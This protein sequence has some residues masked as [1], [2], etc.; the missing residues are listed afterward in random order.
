MRFDG[1]DAFAESPVFNNIIKKEAS[2]L[3]IAFVCF[4]GSRNYNL[5]TDKSDYDFFIIYYPVFENFFTHNFTRFSVIEKDYDY[6]I[7]PFHEYFRHAMNGN[8]KFIEPL[9]CGTFK[10]GIKDSERFFETLKLTEKIKNF[11]LI[12]FEKN[13][14]AVLGIIKNKKINVEKD[15]Y[16]SNTL[17]YKD[18]YGYDIKEAINSLRLSYLLENYIKTGEFSFIVK[19]N[20]VY[21]EFENYMNEINAGN[22]SKKHYLDIINK[23][24]KDLEDLRQ[25]SISKEESVKSQLIAAKREIENDIMNI[26]KTEACFEI[27]KNV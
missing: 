13:F 7:T 2:K 1:F 15:N 22:I 12:N 17:K 6:F 8:I 5:E 27:E 19:R 20:Y 14:D 10:S 23:K 3:N 25:V 16:T 11:I 24:I 9:I 18:L 4:Y 21:E 26:C